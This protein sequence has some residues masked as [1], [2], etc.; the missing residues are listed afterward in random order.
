MKTVGMFLFTVCFLLPSSTAYGDAAK[1]VRQGV[2]YYRAQEFKKASNAFAEADVAKPDNDRIT[3]DRA[4]A[5]AAQGDTE[6]AKE[7]YRTAA[8]SRDI[9]LGG[10][11]SLQPW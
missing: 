7:L 4:C 11:L 3:F 8:L 1:K 9:G 5:Y 6:K 2:S 10:P